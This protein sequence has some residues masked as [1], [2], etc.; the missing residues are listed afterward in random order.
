MSRNPATRYEFTILA[1]GE[2]KDDAPDG[3]VMSPNGKN[4]KF[5]R[6]MAE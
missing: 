3:D 4:S 5:K 6:M 2:N 1:V